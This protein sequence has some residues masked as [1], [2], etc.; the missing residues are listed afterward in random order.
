M[1]GFG[2]NLVQ[3]REWGLIVLQDLSYSRWANELWLHVETAPYRGLFLV[4]EVTAASFGYTLNRP[5]TD[6]VVMLLLGIALRAVAFGLMLRLASNA[7]KRM[8]R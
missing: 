5:I 3:G 7:S 1:N 8:G 4:E 2:P 6:I